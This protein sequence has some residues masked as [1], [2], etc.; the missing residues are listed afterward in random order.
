MREVLQA[1]EPSA[2]AGVETKTSP[3]APP[4]TDVAD[5]AQFGGG[6]VSRPCHAAD[7]GR[8]AFVLQS[9]CV[10]RSQCF[11]ESSCLEPDP[12]RVVRLFPARHDP[13]VL[14][15]PGRRSPPLFHQEPPA[16][17]HFIFS[18]MLGHTIWRSL[19]LIVLGI[20]LRSLSSSQTNFTFEDTLT[21]IGLGYTF[22]FLLAF[23]PTR[24]NGLRLAPSFLDTGWPGRFIV[25][26]VRTSTTPR[27]ACPPIGITFTPAFALT[28]TRTATLARPSICGS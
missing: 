27:S 8:S 21:Q 25:L 16:Q 17:G 20:F 22:L 3:P 23:R 9:L 24:D 4:S 14:L 28:G 26:P 10:L 12:F 15:L 7:D 19:L 13:A 5:R 11:L 6:R 18:R 2:A 1:E